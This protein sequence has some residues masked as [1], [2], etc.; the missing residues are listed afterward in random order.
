MAPQPFQNGALHRTFC[1][2]ALLITASFAFHNPT[3]IKPK[4]DF[5]LRTHEHSSPNLIST[6]TSCLSSRG[7]DE[8]STPFPKH[9]LQREMLAEAMGT[10]LIVNLGCGVVCSS[11]FHATTSGLYQ[12]AAVWGMAVSIAIYCTASI[13]GAHL[14]P[15]ISVAI[16]LLRNSKKKDGDGGGFGWG[17]VLPYVAAQG[18]GAF[19]GGLVNFGL[20]RDSIVTFERD[21]GI[22]RGSLQSVASAAAFGEYWSVANWQS[23]FFAEALGTAILSFVIFSVTSP[24]NDD[25][26]PKMAPL[27]IGG[28][29]A[30]LITVIAPLTQAGFNPA[31]DFGPRLVTFLAGWGGEVAFKG[32]WVYILAPIVGAVFGGS[33]SK[34]VTGE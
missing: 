19:L 20:F 13:S 31:R 1:I 11:I 16:A 27:L 15:A 29:V 22:V 12:I 7:G 25:I 9:Q 2:L 33:L 21:M 18:M 8:S 14:N 32:W 23:A 3:G 34:L 17:K 24:K 5:G 6:R 28:T 26:P 10:F 4:V 30:S